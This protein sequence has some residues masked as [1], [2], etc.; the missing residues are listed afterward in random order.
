M[1]KKDE[2][3]KAFEDKIK[4]D[5]GIHLINLRIGKDLTLRELAALSGISATS[6]HSSE[7]GIRNTP[8]QDLYALADAL[9][10]ELDELFPYRKA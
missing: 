2:A 7:N 9:G 1:K 10:I 5:F 4:K 3:K 6:L 8:V